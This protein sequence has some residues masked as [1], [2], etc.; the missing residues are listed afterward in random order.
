MMMMMMMMM[1][2]DDDDDDDNND[3]NIDDKHYVFLRI[4]VYNKLLSRFNCKGVLFISQTLEASQ[5][6]SVSISS[7]K[8]L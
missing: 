2:I 6:F 3:N 7:N 8:L 1:M 4:Y 5:I